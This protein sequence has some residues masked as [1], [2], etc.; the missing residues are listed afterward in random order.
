MFSVK[1]QESG[2]G[3]HMSMAWS[4]MRKRRR[5]EGR[6]L[7][8][9][10]SPRRGGRIGAGTYTGSDVLRTPLS[11]LTRMKLSAATW[12][13]FSRFHFLSVL[14]LSLSLTLTLS[15][16]HGFTSSTLQPWLMLAGTIFGMC[17]ML[18]IYWLNSF[19]VCVCVTCFQWFFKPK[20]WPAFHC[21]VSDE[22]VIYVKLL[23]NW[24]LLK[25][26]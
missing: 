21:W 7:R 10:S 22:Q 3:P 14:T 17:Y 2:N 4:R 12:P 6:K 15:L 19:C 13:T 16:S 9:A 8:S 18:S 20:T 11:K 26:Y 5:R 23:L 1:P 25:I 24:N